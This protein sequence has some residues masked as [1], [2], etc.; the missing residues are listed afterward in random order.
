MNRD[1]IV[2]GIEWVRACVEEIATM[3][4]PSDDD[5]SRADA[6]LESNL[7]NVETKQKTGGGIAANLARLKATL[8]ARKLIP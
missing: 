3:P 2:A 6:G 1:E 5:L 7:H 8:A 4:E